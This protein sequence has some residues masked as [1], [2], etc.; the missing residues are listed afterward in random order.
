MTEQSTRQHDSSR[1]RPTLHTG[2][3]ENLAKISITGKSTR[4]KTPVPSAANA[5]AQS[6]GIVSTKALKISI[7]E[8]FNGTPE[9]I[10]E[11]LIQLKL[12]ILFN[13][14]QFI[15]ESD[16]VLYASSYLRGRAARSFRP[17]LKE[18]L[19]NQDPGDQPNR[20]TK[21]I[22]RNYQE[23]KEKLESLYRISN[24]EAHADREIRKLRQTTSVTVYASEFQGF[25]AD[26][27]QNDVTFRLQFY[28]GLKDIIKSE[29]VRERKTTTLTTLISVIK[30]VDERLQELR[31][32]RNFDTEKF[33]RSLKA[34]GRYSYR[35]D[36][37]ELD[38]TEVFR[39]R[40]NRERRRYY[41]C[42][43]QG[44]IVT[45]CKRPRENIVRKELAII[46]VP[47]H[48]QTRWNSC[49]DDD[50]TSHREKKEQAGIFPPSDGED[51]VV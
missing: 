21:L 5:T 14:A 43:R 9:K 37:M 18:W 8:T 41:R 45:E 51:S 40:K 28:L 19:S 22:F 46:T 50:Y 1:Q 12:Y 29:L 30:E 36:P 16:K 27:G 34:T 3:T 7:P 31:Y 6:G 35:P 25:I 26:L 32:D 4:S 38:A 20:E 10:E 23:F 49:Y 2:I 17:Y 39:N 42:G 47:G 33:G 15:R 24:E 13:S 44:H 11:F 48:R